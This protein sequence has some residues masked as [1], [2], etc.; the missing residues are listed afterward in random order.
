[1]PGDRVRAAVVDAPAEVFGDERDAGRQLIGKHGA[2][3]RAVRD[4]EAEFEDELAAAESGGTLVGIVAETRETDDADVRRRVCGK[5]AGTPDAREREQHHGGRAGNE[6]ARRFMMT[7][8][9]PL[10]CPAPT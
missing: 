2:L 4:E 8:S 9:P 1:M 7:S 10:E 3:D 5:G 6:I